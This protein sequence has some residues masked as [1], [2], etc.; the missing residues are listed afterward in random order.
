LSRFLK[1]FVFI[2][3]FSL[4]RKEFF[5]GFYGGKAAFPKIAERFYCSAPPFKMHFAKR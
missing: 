3:S 4:L 2:R 5:T 1:F